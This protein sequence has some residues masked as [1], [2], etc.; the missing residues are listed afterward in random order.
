MST[1]GAGATRLRKTVFQAV[2]GV[3]GLAGMHERMHER[4]TSPDMK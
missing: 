4:L 2:L 1:E 3:A